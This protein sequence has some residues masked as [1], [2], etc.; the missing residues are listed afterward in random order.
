MRSR[1]PEEY[2]QRSHQAHEPAAAAGRSSRRLRAGLLDPTPAARIRLAALILFAIALL[3]SAW[4]SDDAF[5]TF[6]TIDNFWHGY[7][8]RWNVVERVQS[9]T[10]PLWMLVLAAPFGVLRDPQWTTFL[11]SFLCTAGTLALLLW[12]LP[13]WSAAGA[14]LVLTASRAFVD[15][16]TSGLEN[17]LSFLLLTGF[18]LLYLMDDTR[19]THGGAAAMAAAPLPSRGRRLF[20]LALLASL[21]VLNRQDLLLLV[22]PAL[23]REAWRVWTRQPRGPRVALSTLA[24][25]AVPLG[26]WHLFSLIYYGFLLPNTAYAKLGHGLP[27]A[28]LIAQGFHYLG[29][30]LTFDPVTMVTIVAALVIGAIAVRTLPGFAAIVA[31]LFLHVA[32][33]VWVGGDFMSGRFLTPAFLTSVVVLASLVPQ[34]WPRRTLIAV[35]ALLLLSLAT[36][37]SP[38]RVTA[39]LPQAGRVIPAP[40][41]IMDERVYYYPYTGLIQKLRGIQVRNQSWAAAGAQA[42]QAMCVREFGSI[43]LFGYFAGPKVHLID[44][45]G[46]GDPLMA[47]LPATSG[48]RIGHFTRTPPHG[49]TATQIACQQRLFP[50]GEVSPTAT[51]ETCLSVWPEINHLEDPRMGRGYHELLRITQGPLFDADRAWQIMRWNLRLARMPPDPD[52]VR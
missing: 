49:Y 46:L 9:Y 52:G 32:Y 41:G 35:A 44:L 34:R 31:G 26:L 33:I 18:W 39:A 15:Y 5:I 1:P 13:M 24:L 10:H 43:G 19:A 21:T 29:D 25:A 3:R 45:Y 7:G 47:R 6:R 51:Q 11:V 14:V 28:A 30:S 12:R 48:W 4:V 38:L 16:S 22:A 23:L 17:P 42:G 37:G 50:T 2:R 8:L 20:W 27:R 36:T 40:Q